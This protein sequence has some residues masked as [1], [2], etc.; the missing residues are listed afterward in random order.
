[1]LCWQSGDGK[2]RLSAWLNHFSPLAGVLTWA[3]LPASLIVMGC[4]FSPDRII[5][6]PTT[7]PLSTIGAVRRLLPFAGGQLEVWV[8]R[9][10][11]L[12]P[13]QRPDAYFLRFYGNADRA[14]PNAGTEAWEWQTPAVE[15]W[16]VNYPGFG[17]S[18]GPAT[19]ARMGPAALAAFDA[20]KAAAGGRPNRRLR[21]E[22]R[23]DRRPARRG[24]TARRGAGHPAKTH[25]PCARSPCGKFGW[26]NLWLIAGPLSLRIPSALDSVANARQVHTP[27]IFLL[28]ERDGTV[29]PRYQRL[30]VEAYAGP[31]RIFTLAGADHNDPPDRDTQAGICAVVKANLSGAPGPLQIR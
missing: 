18:T 17:G 26:W 20:L 16:G 15:I 27:G 5:L 22:R 25:R 24:A 7:E 2:E 12:A 31:K 29:L 11:S 14:D 23:H 10:R 6:H 13:G 30:V 1:M 8:A 28:S 9:S 4:A 19:L 3:L 21:H